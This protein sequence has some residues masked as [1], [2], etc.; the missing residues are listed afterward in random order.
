MRSSIDN[1]ITAALL[2]N[3]NHLLQ[4]AVSARRRADGLRSEQKAKT[5]IRLYHEYNT[6]DVWS[7]PEQAWGV[8]EWTQVESAL[9]SMS[10]KE[11]EPYSKDDTLRHI[12]YW[13]ETRVETRED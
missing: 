9:W 1:T 8:G 3:A 13:V 2:L 6:V 5:Y 11:A 12:E 4:H 7:D 10:E